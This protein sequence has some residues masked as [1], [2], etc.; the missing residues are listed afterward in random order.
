MSSLLVCDQNFM[1]RSHALSCMLE[2]I[3]RKIRVELSDV[4]TKRLLKGLAQVAGAQCSAANQ[5][6]L[7]CG[8]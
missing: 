2:A 3:A 4:M 1:Q 5:P 7:E 6:Q 8:S